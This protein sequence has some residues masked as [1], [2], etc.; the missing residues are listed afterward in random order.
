MAFPPIVLISSAVRTAFSVKKSRQA[1]CAPACAKAMA[2]AR[3]I[4]WPAPVTMATLPV[5]EYLLRI[6]SMKFFRFK[7]YQDRLL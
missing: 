3:Q 1:T 6:F 2:I 7:H 4:P 5:S